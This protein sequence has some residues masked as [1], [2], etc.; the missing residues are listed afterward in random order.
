MKRSRLLVAAVLL[1]PLP[2]CLLL[3]PLDDLASGGASAPDAAPD[4]TSP[5]VPVPAPP[6]A[7]ID[8]EAGTFCQRQSPSPTFCVDFDRG[9]P[10]GFDWLPTAGEGDVIALDPLAF[11]P[12][13]SALVRKAAPGCT[14]LH[15]AQQFFPKTR[16][17][18]SFMMRTSHADAGSHKG[19]FGSMFIR[20]AENR[21]CSFIFDLPG[22]TG[23]GFSENRLTP[24]SGTDAYHYAS[25]YPIQERWTKFTLEL[26]PRAEGSGLLANVW[27]DDVPAMV[28]EP[29]GSCH[30]GGNTTLRLGP[31]CSSAGNELRI[32][33]VVVS[34][35]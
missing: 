31:S 10:V 25:R 5:P 14:P 24:D 3:T 26:R 33:D 20:D 1:G 30:L 6:D 8:A 18:A 12:P 22:E 2:A 15:L 9:D 32:D 4:V 35:E 13:S 34:V 27:L 11:S 16:F 7:G 19:Y 17:R 23:L 29:L 21:G 28:D